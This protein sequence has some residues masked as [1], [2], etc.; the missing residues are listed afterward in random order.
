MTDDRVTYDA[1]SDRYYVD[2]D[3]EGTASV[4]DAVIY[5]IADIREMD[6]IELPPLGNIVDT[7]AL[8]NIFRPDTDTPSDLTVTFEYSGFIVSINGHGRVYLDEHK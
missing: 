3:L 8:G 4:T 2:V 6:P 5:G 7:D 1:S